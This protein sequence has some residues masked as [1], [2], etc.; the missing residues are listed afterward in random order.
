M[1]DRANRAFDNRVRV[2][3]KDFVF[4]DLSIAGT[5]KVLDLGS[6]P[7][8]AR[9][10]GTRVALATPFTGGAISAVSAKLGT[11]GDDDALLAAADIL[12]A[13]VD[14]EASTHTNGISPNKKFAAGAALKAT[15]TSTG[16]NLSA[17]TAGA[18]TIE[19]MYALADSNTS[20]GT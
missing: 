7:N 10:L 3:S 12:S 18:C 6:L 15:F 8:N 14:G 17:L 20:L 2:L 13:A 11:T 5:S 9:V 19:V 1:F 4:G 16:A